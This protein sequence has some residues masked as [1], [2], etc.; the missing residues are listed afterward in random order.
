MDQIMALKQQLKEQKELNEQ[1][2]FQKSIQQSLEETKL[3]RN[4][5]QG[6]TE[7]M[8]ESKKFVA[9]KALGFVITKKVKGNNELD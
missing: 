3:D 9:T 6:N 1:K 5:Y 2:H 7:M 4:P 8:I